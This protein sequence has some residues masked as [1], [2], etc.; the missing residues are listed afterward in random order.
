MLNLFAGGNLNI[1]NQSGG[2]FGNTGNPGL[3]AGYAKGQ[4]FVLN[5][6]GGTLSNMIGNAPV[7][8]DTGIPNTAAGAG[9]MAYSVVNLDSDANGTVGKMIT[10]YLRAIAEPGCQLQR[11]CHPGRIH[12]GLP[13]L[14]RRR[15]RV[16]QRQ[17]HHRLNLG[18]RTQG[19]FPNNG[20]VGGIFV[21]QKGAIFGTN[22]LEATLGSGVPGG[23]VNTPDHPILAPT[24]QGVTSIPVSN[25]GSGYLSPP[26]VVITDASGDTTGIDATAFATI[27]TNPADSTYG[28]VTKITI[29]SPG[30]N[31]TVP[32]IITLVGGGAASA[33]TLGAPAIAQNVTTGGFT[34]VDN[35]TL[36]LNGG[37]WYMN[38]GSAQTGSPVLT[39]Q[40]TTAQNTYGGP[41]TVAAGTLQLGTVYNASNAVIIETNTQNDAATL[42]INQVSTL[43]NSAMTP[44]NNSFPTN[45][46]I[47]VVGDQPANSTLTNVGTLQ[48]T[49][50]GTGGVSGFALGFQQVLA[51]FGNVT[52]SGT[53]GLNIGQAPSALPPERLL[54][55]PIRCRR[56]PRP[57]TE[58]TVSWRPATQ[59]AARPLFFS[60]TRTS[61]SRTTRCTVPLWSGPAVT[62]RRPSPSTPRPAM[63]RRL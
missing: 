8:I 38:P 5:V 17:S 58:Q 10:G 43:N 27:D 7:Y 32:P 4:D 28:Q 23:N 9:F 49:K 51:G 12:F 21:F 1:G 15:A 22:G 13:Q 37:Y 16:Q 3:N 44:V 59:P 2:S 41:T 54:R 11:R 39:N 52:G 24:G 26:A 6:Y 42:Q 46:T 62:A 18:R 50:T 48:I 19:S 35:G 53:E 20:Y 57:S 56:P 36:T 45:G 29:T 30:I 63:Q 14:Q 61:I 47:F 55:S 34:K 25:G 33:A 31:Y 60:T 40:L